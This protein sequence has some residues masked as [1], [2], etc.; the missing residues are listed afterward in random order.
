MTIEESRRGGKDA[1]KEPVKELTERQRAV[2]NWIRGFVLENQMPPTVREIGR[3]F[4]I[5]SAGVF[6][7]LKALERKGFLKRGKLGARSLE[8]SPAPAQ[9]QAGGF[10][11]RVPVVGRI[12][13]GVPLLAIENV[14]GFIAVDPGFLKG[15]GGDFFALK[16]KGDSMI[17]AGIHEGDFVIARKQDT[18]DDGDIVVALI[19]DEATL[20]RFRRER[21]RVFLEPANRRMKPIYPSDLMIQGVAKVVIRKM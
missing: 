15:E 4:R 21:N 7:H 2:L 3:E 19:E 14:D 18:A 10:L 20:K 6:G 5:S 11:S 17:E 16:V 12:A 9:A 1:M 13:A 8:L